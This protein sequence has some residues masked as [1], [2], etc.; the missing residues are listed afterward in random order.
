MLANVHDLR[1]RPYRWKTVL[2]VVQSASKDNV[3][4]DSD[5]VNSKLGV[6][7]DYAEREGISV[8]DAVLWA[9]GMGGMVTLYLYDVDPE[10]TPDEPPLR[11]S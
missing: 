10:S 7:I 4:E 9:E 6:E 1:E 8:R 5:R 2:A 11:Q 3:A